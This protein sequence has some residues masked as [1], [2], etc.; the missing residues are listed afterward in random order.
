M[1]REY[2]PAVGKQRSIEDYDKL[3]QQY[4]GKKRLVHS[5]AVA[6]AA[7]KLAQRFAPELVERP[8]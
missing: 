2:N 8:E 4:L 6:D 3:L 5:R 1:G 7:R